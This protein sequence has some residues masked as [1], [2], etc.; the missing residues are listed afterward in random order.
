[1]GREWCCFGGMLDDSSVFEVE[2]QVGY[3]YLYNETGTRTLSWELVPRQRPQA[4]VVPKQIPVTP[5]W[6]I[7]NQ[8]QHGPISAK[9]GIMKSRPTTINKC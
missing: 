9:N 7:S 3:Q 8:L 5:H 6:K 2:T 4:V 1:M